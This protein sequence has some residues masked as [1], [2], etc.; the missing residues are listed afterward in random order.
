VG[1]A[2]ILAEAAPPDE[3]VLTG[4]RSA[5]ADVTVKADT[6]LHI[7]RVTTTAKGQFVGFYVEAVD[8][9]FARRTERGR[10]HG[11]VKVRD[12][13]APGQPPVA[14][15]FT[16][17][18]PAGN[19]LLPGRYRFYL[20]ADG[21]STVRI[22]TSGGLSGRL[23]PSKPAHAAVASDDDIL[24][25]PIAASNAQPL[26]LSGARSV[27]FSGILAGEFRAYAGFIGACLR[28]GEDCGEQGIDGSFGGFFVSP[29]ADVDVAFAISYEPGVLRPGE[30]FADQ[31]ATN[32]TT[33]KYASAAAFTLTL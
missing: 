9:P 15:S 11:V 33:F 12:W 23:T 6:R 22:P 31:A 26:T 29:L 24:T 13:H 7:D 8:V 5:S 2:P 19:V 25:S 27:N 17:P 21:P 3:L 10:R 28:V 14:F 16:A 32:V 1:A 30:Y 4:T 20:L 18:D